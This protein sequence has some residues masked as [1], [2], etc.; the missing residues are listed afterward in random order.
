M[1]RITAYVCSLHALRPTP[2]QIANLFGGGVDKLPLDQRER[3]VIEHMDDVM[4]SVADPLGQKGGKMWWQR[5]EDPWQCL[6]ACNE[7]TKAMQSGDPAAFMSSL[8]VQQVC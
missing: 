3:Y 4:D 7:L 8:P 5:A 6:A 2:P 1:H